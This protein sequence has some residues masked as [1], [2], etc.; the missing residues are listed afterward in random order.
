MNQPP[1]I[2]PK[3]AINYFTS[4]IPS[5]PVPKTAATDK[6]LLV[7]IILTAVIALTPIVAGAI[8][9]YA[10]IQIHS[11]QIAQVQADVAW[12]ESHL[13]NNDYLSEDE[14]YA[15]TDTLLRQVRDLSSEVGLLKAQLGQYKN[16]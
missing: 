2:E 11:Y 6:A 15:Y 3:P 5:L 13:I 10:K 9:L 8:V 12:V 1:P 7:K 4:T 14:A 16:E